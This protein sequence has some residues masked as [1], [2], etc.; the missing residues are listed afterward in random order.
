[1][2]RFAPVGKLSGVVGR[3][4]AFVAE[5]YPL[6]M[7]AALAVIEAVTEFSP[8]DYDEQGINAFRPVFRKELER[9]LA[10]H[11][12][13]AGLP[14]PTPRITAA[15]RL[16][17]A[18]L[19]LLDA[20]DGF[21]RRTAIEA[22]LTADERREM[23][24]AMLLARA[25]DN[26]LKTFFTSG[27]VRYGTAVFQGKGFRSLGQE[28]ICG[29]AVR[30]RRGDAFRGPDGKWTGDVVSPLIRDL[31][32]ALMM[33][34]DPATVRMA[35][36][37]Q[38]GKS[39]LPY[40]GKD[41]TIG[42]FSWGIF[43]PPSP[44][45]TAVLAVAGLAMGFW[46]EG[47]GRVAVSFI[48]DGGCSLGEWHEAINLCAARRLPAIFCIQNNQTA[49]STPLRDQTGVRV[50]ADKAVGY[51]VPGITVDGTVH[52]GCRASARRRRAKPH[53]SGSHA[54]VWTRAS[55]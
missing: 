51:G 25:V 11:P 54:D 43:P 55:R 42:D 10:F 32:C 41:I 9:R 22:S 26:R 13:T 19:E 23:L 50:F 21:L 34:Q 1:M 6:A 44:L 18:H 35:L 48:G 40:D 7:N 27:E 15:Q 33:R 14:E 38:M 45:A 36:N 12:L 28:A 8:T 52:V 39:G 46:R 37:A 29:A 16:E 49:L 30:L 17:Q 3:L 53:R 24:R 47:S 20:C 31:A 5:R 2:A 4:A